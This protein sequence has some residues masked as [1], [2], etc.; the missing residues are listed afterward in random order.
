MLV[1][2]A[3]SI[4]SNG[5]PIR[6]LS[7]VLLPRLNCPRAAS[8]NCFASAAAAAS[9][10][11]EANPGSPRSLVRDSRTSSGR[12]R[13][14]IGCSGLAR[15]RQGSEQGRPAESPRAPP[16]RVHDGQQLDLALDHDR[17]GHRR[18]QRPRGR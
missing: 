7:S 8:V 12:V 11:S 17:G 1:K 15:F 6:A 10:I 13:W 14:V 5:L 18:R 9:A 16:L 4:G 2:G 3:T